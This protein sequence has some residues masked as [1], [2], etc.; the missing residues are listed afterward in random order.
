MGNGSSYIDAGQ[1]DK[2]ECLNERGENSDGHEGK[3]KEIGNDGSD[4][5]DQEFLGKNISEEPDGKGHRPGE[6]AHELDRE[7]QGGEKRNW[8]DKMLEI[9]EQPLSFDS[10]PVIVNE[11]HKGT[12]GRHIEFACRRHEAGDQSYQ[13]G[14]EN[15]KPYRGDHW[16]V[17]FPFLS[18]GVDQQALK[19]L[20][21]HF[22]KTLEPGWEYTDPP[23]GEAEEKD[24]KKN[25]DQADH[26]VIG[27]EMERV[28]YLNAEQT[29]KG[30][31]RLAED[32]IDKLY[33]RQTVF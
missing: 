21:D 13:V 27:Q 33:K 7:H 25:D 2:Y 32:F 11:Y 31:Q 19:C 9:F 14:K 5:Q 15:K 10:L 1:E 12:P 6:M 4:D 3:G 23:G 8:A 16:K 26:D 28:F 22:Q 29:Q 30:S 20:D 24:E 17:F 18:D